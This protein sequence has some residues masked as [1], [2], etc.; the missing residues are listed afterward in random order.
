[1]LRGRV[2]VSKANMTICSLTSLV[3]SRE[4]AMTRSFAVIAID[5][6]VPTS[7]TTVAYINTSGQLVAAHD[8]GVID[9]SSIV[10]LA[11]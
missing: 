9:L 7:L 5:T 8:C 4:Y 1:M 6:S 3:D 10:L 2:N 11:K